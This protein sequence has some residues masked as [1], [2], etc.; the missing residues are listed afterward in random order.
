MHPI[1]N[2]GLRF[3]T[4]SYC[5]TSAQSPFSFAL[6]GVINLETGSELKTRTLDQYSAL[7]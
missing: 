7:L 1:R 6:S 5:Q 3:V 4:I 2:G